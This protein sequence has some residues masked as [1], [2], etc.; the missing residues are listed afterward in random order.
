M[1]SIPIRGTRI[2]IMK[3]HR[4]TVKGRDWGESKYKTRKWERRVDIVRWEHDY[5][6]DEYNID[7]RIK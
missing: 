6:N 4:I 3:T 5:V 1:G 2:L 7:I